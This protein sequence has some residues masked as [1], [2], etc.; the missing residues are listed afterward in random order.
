MYDIF[1]SWDHFRNDYDYYLIDNM[2][3][4]NNMW[5]QIKDIKYL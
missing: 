2:T 4:E 5:I 1:I 3:I